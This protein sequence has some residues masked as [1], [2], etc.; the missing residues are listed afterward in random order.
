MNKFP[1]LK[2]SNYTSSLKFTLHVVNHPRVEV[3]RGICKKGDIKHDFTHIQERIHSIRHI[4][5]FRGDPVS[6]IASRN[7]S[8]TF[9]EIQVHSQNSLEN[10][11]TD[12]VNSIQ[13]R[14]PNEGFL[15]VTSN[16]TSEHQNPQ[17]QTLIPQLD[18][19]DLVYNR[20]KFPNLRH[21]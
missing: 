10:T 13:R 4:R 17:N 9:K 19:I 5:G 8:S 18:C 1:F 14:I 6:N 15:T 7:T 3:E 16:E 12:F 11:N 2:H 21:E 20:R